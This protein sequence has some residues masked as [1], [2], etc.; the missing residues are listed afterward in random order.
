MNR[1]ERRATQ[2][3]RARASDA[4]ARPAPAGLL[5]LAASHHNQGRPRDAI[6]VLR[7]ILER[8]P[9]HAAAHD[10]IAEAY[11]T[12]GR[13]DA[14]VRHFREAIACG[15]YGTE[16]AVKQSPTMMIALG[17][18]SQAYP[19][20]LPL[21]ELLGPDNSVAKDARL[22]ALLQ[23]EIA[24]DVEIELFLTAVRQA[25]LVALTNNDEAVSGTDV[26]DFAC[27]LAQQCFLNEYVFA[28]SEAERESVG[29]LYDRVGQGGTT[30]TAAELA[31]LGCY[32]PLG[33]LPGAAKLLEQPWPKAVDTLLTRQVREP[34]AEAS[35]MAAIP[36]LTAVEDPTSRSVQQ[37]YE[38][39][40][41]PRWSLPLPCRPTTLGAFLHDRFGL[42]GPFA[43]D[44]LVA[45]CGTGEHSTDIA[46][47]FPGSKVL[48]I[49]ISRTSLAYAR[50][51]TRE[52][53]IRNLDYAQADILKL[54]SLDRRFDL[55]ESVGVL[56][57]M[58]DPETG[59]SGLIP[60]LRPGGVMRIALYSE[61]GRRPLDTGRAL[62][63]E[64]GYG[65]TADDIRL[66]RQELIRRGQPVPSSDFFSISSCRDLCFH[67]MEHR[68][69]LPRIKRFLETHALELLGLETSAE[70]RRLFVQ[71]NPA[72][73]M[74]T[75]LDR[76]DAFE[77]AHPRTFASM[78][79][80]WIRAAGGLRPTST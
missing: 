19:R 41:Y 43:G 33:S 36:A 34:L 21:S 70:T 39:N 14:A 57:H 12:L 51:K 35:D 79:Y 18:F 63:A 47:N 50:R 25:L 9:H 1:K 66:W 5:A 73:S 28:L 4:L 77:R 58:S 17:R 2:N 53:G 27:A 78:Y 52:L 46:R 64:R 71:D 13:S 3:G 68:F 72:P 61:I 38:E 74:L 44:I 11:Q 23:T 75:D 56:H 24:R 65:A 31:V 76:W 59:W 69:T 49:D 8:E 7:Q 37:Q 15:Q 62:I 60:L 45:G 80:V 30:A 6:K 67:V 26:L 10:S 29:G 16:T 32:R 40:P 55:I 54:G 48:A 22:L 20:K 42:A